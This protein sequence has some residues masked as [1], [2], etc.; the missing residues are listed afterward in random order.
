MGVG[1]KSKVEKKK[2]EEKERKNSLAGK[3]HPPANAG[4]QNNDL[5]AF[6]R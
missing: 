1:S 3:R 2:N 5:P 6:P 4:T